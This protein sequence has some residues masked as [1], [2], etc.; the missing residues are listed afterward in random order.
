MDLQ[1]AL[2][3]IA[4]KLPSWKAR[5]LTKDGRLIY[6]QSVMMASVIYQLMAL[7]LEPWF[8]K[9]VDKLRRGFL[10]VG[11][12][13]ARGGNCLV[14]WSAVCQPKSVG[15]LG[16]HNLRW[17]NAALRTRWIW[18]Q[19]SGEERSWAGLQ[20]QVLPEAKAMF[21]ASVRISVGSGERIVFWED[22]WINGLNVAA[23]APDVLALV[24]IGTQ[25]KRLVREGLEGNAWARDIAG[26]LSI[27]AVVQCLA[28]WQ[29]IANVQHLGD[30]DGF[31]WKWTSSG[32]FSSRSAYHAFFAGSTTLPCAPQVWHSFA[33]LK[34]RLHAWFAIRD[35]CWTVDRR[36]RRGLASHSIC[37]CCQAADETMNH[38][39]MQCAFAGAV[40]SGIIQRLGVS[41][42]LPNVLSILTDWWPAAVRTL[43]RKDQKTANSLIMLTIWELWLERNARVFENKAATA[44]RVIDVIVDEWGLWASCRRGIVSE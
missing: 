12:E 11:R 2:D 14:A 18:L 31:V 37:L 3:K 25:R 38:I 28:L 13:E 44:Q 26:E 1:P 36:L 7:D 15:G 6:V 17:L 16:L 20:F 33:P 27:N 4:N 32:Q 23:I 34:I 39:T 19:R 41:L 5:L 8:F 29:S 9:A 43:A 10:W 40:W 30:L 42:P 24:P 21:N 22:P 35:R